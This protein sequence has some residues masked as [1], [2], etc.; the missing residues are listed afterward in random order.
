MTEADV[1]ARSRPSTVSRAALL[2][3]LFLIVYASW[4]PFTGWRKSG[5]SPLAFANLEWPRYW[6]AFDASVNVI[7]YIPLGV[8]IVYSM[9][10][11]VRGVLAVI[12][13]GSAIGP[14]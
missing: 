4:F 12:S 6:T 11:R 7:G 10:P 8:L 3:Y 1:P 2:A 14:S 5:L 9:Y 13:R